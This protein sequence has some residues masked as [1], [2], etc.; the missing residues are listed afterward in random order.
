MIALNRLLLFI[1]FLFTCCEDA[2]VDVKSCEHVGK[3]PVMGE[4][5]KSASNF[6]DV[7]YIIFEKSGKKYTVFSAKIDGDPIRLL[8]EDSIHLTSVPGEEIY[9][10]VKSASSEI[11]SNFNFEGGKSGSGVVIGGYWLAIAVERESNNCIAYSFKW[12]GR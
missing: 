4:S 6:K 3:I 12:D 9:K 8:A 5:L 2:G 11:A 10:F 7:Q 1:P